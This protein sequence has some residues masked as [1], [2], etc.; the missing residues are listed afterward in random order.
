VI[1]AAGQGKRM[2]SHCPR[3][4]CRWPD[5]PL[6]AHVL[7]TARELAPAAVHVVYGHGATPCRARSRIRASASCCRPSS[8]APA[9][10]A[11]SDAGDSR[12]R[13]R[14]GAL[15]RRA[16]D[17][18]GHAQALLASGEPLAVLGAKLDDPT[19]Y[20][21]L[22]PDDDGR[23]R[24]IVEERDAKPEER[25]IP[26]VNTGIVAAD[27]ARLRV[28]RLARLKTQHAGRALSHDVFALAHRDG[29][30]R[31]ARAHARRERGAGR[32]RRGQLAELET[33]LN[34]GRLAVLMEGGR[35]HLEPGQR[36]GARHGARG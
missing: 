34:Y 14:A 10:R 26:F 11:T 30:G 16:A 5:G 12:R 36:V 6:L 29:V 24:A 21:R 1:L 13:A 4:C 22:L 20:G 3:C 7:D 25:E 23:V 27:A 33:A 15:R 9:R 19:G 2:R 32:E 17:H 35:A 31:G 18:R 28:A 8:A